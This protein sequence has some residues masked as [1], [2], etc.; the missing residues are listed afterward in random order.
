MWR[1][2]SLKGADFNGASAGVLLLATVSLT[3]IN[4]FVVG[5]CFFGVVQQAS[6]FLQAIVAD[7]ARF[8]I[9]PMCI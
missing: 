8:Q 5:A 9:A 6:S 7:I 3:Q 4:Q 1:L 2:L